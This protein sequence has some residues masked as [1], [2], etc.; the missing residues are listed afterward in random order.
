MRL[1]PRGGAASAGR[2]ISVMPT[3]AKDGILAIDALA[4]KG[5]HV[6][7]M[8]Q[9]MDAA[10]DAAL[11]VPVAGGCGSRALRALDESEWWR[12]VEQV[13]GVDPRAVGLCPL[14]SVPGSPY[15]RAQWAR[16]ALA[17]WLMGH[18]GLRIGELARLPWTSLYG[19]G[20]VTGACVLS[21]PVAKGNHPRTVPLDTFTL[22]AIERA[23]SSLRDMD[24]DGGGYRVWGVGWEWRPGGVRR[25]RDVVGAFGC[26]AGLRE[27]RP[28]ELRH[29]Y[30]TRLARRARLHVVQQLLGHRSLASTQRYLDVTW[31]DKADA[32]SALTREVD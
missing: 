20:G 4:V 21:A 3:L 14:G 15:R 32:V 13:E 6:G 12:L 26:A 2:Q 29:T 5:Y 18:A 22:G 16:D 11:V 9:V 25:I 17:I 28:H 31:A 10:D 30:A 19:D 1:C 7:T 8:D 24:R 23:R 27:I